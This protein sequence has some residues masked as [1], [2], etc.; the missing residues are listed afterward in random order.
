M[1]EVEWKKKSMLYAPP[2][3]DK[4][5]SNAASKKTM[6]H[7]NPQQVNNTLNSNPLSRNT[8]GL[9]NTQL[10]Q[11]GVNSYNQNSFF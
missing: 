10:T 1:S 9:N 2:T 5:G 6:K 8:Q 4:K 7:S 3:K 11:N